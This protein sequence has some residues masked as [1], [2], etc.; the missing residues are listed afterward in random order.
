MLKEVM[1]GQVKYY[2]D[3]GEL[4]R[5]SILTCPQ[6]ELWTTDY[7][8]KGRVYLEMKD[9][10]RQQQE[11]IADYFDKAFPVLDI[12]CGFG[13]QAILLARLGYQVTGI[14]TSNV[15]INIAK[16]L[17][18]RHGYE[19]NFIYTDLDDAALKG[20]YK[21]LLLLDVVEH[22]R[23]FER[24]SFFGK[25]RKIMTPDA[26]LIISLPHVKKR[27]SSQLNNRVRRGITQYIP[28]FLKKEEH[29][30]PVPG[31]NTILKI[32]S[33]FLYLNKFI[34]SEQTDYYVFVGKA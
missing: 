6:P 20:P 23:P 22:I 30:Y 25:L 31:K 16:E 26:V 33:Q 17:F 8:E 1:R 13:R 18:A 10:I 7:A 34:G 14:D 3:F 5:E 9:R 28:Y 11:L 4:N 27:I 15:F 32:V 21:Q 19:G 29:P 12:G 2:N 24:K